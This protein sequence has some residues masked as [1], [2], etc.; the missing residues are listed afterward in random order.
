MSRLLQEFAVKHCNELEVLYTL[1]G[2]LKSEP[3]TYCVKLASTY[4]LEG[5][6]C[7]T[8]LT[9]TFLSTCILTVSLYQTASL[10]LALFNCLT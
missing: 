4:K 7:L 2:W 1:S 6:I 9:P 10:Y 5:Y 8:W 3:Q